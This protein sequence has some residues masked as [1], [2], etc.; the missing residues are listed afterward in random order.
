M[1]TEEVITE[2]QIHIIDAIIKEAKVIE[3]QITEV[4]I[5]IIDVIIKEAIII[6]VQ[7]CVTQVLIKEGMIIKGSD[8]KKC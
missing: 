3:V 7:I 2:V 4:Q 5:H 6:E 1:I 8:D